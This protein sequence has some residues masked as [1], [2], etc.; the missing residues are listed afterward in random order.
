MTKSVTIKTSVAFLLIFAIVMTSL[1]SAFAK[2]NESDIDESITLIY[3]NSYE[4]GSEGK[5][6]KYTTTSKAVACVSD[7][8]TIK[9]MGRGTCIVRATDTA[10]AETTVY[11]VQ[12]KVIWW[13]IFSNLI[14]YFR[15][16]KCPVCKAGGNEEP[17]TTE[18]ST[19]EIT[20]G[21]TTEPVTEPTTEPT[22]QKPLNAYEIPKTVEG[23]NETITHNNFDTEICDTDGNLNGY[24]VI[25][26]IRDISQ[27]ESFTYNGKTYAADDLTDVSE[28]SSTY[29]SYKTEDYGR[30]IM[31][32]NCL[33]EQL[34]V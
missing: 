8:G 25:T 2:V 4:L 21:S 29:I 15:N 28:L 24:Y 20:T 6:C 19:T 3:G 7:S 32:V 33:E 16:K 12:V 27:I 31:F 22:T 5:I 13:R 18:P 23:A 30:F 17:F 34:V 1:M 11:S 9:S 26:P 10:T 14:Y